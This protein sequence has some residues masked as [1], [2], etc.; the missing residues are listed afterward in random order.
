MSKLL[1]N[2]LVFSHIG[3][4]IYLKNRKDFSCYPKQM[5]DETK[6]VTSSI[7]DNRDRGSV[8]S[9]LSD[10]IKSDAKL[11]FVSAYFTIFA[12]HQLK[13]QLDEVNHLQFLFGEPAF[14][15]SLGGDTNYLRRVFTEY[16]T[17]GENFY[18]DRLYWVF[19][20][21]L[22]NLNEVRE[23]HD[24][25]K[26]K[27]KR[28]DVPYLNGG[29]FEL[30][31]DGFDERGKV[32]LSNERFAEILE[33]FEKYNFTVEESTPYEVQVAID[34]E[35]LGRVFEELVTGRHESG[36]YYTPRQI[37]SFM[38]RESLKYYLA[39][40]DN[41][42]TIAEFVDEGKG[43]NLNN[44]EKILDAI[45]RIRLCDPACGSGAY[46][47]GMMQE[48]LALRQSLFASKHIGDAWILII[49]I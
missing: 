6:F 48:L 19:F 16:E 3:L 10:K 15:K 34:P 49:T 2:S 36:S 44:P 21:G 41:A 45:K 22:S 28:G 11:S 30:E 1:D 23:I 29:L 4:H 20:Y 33:L 26:L 17:H 47:L 40:F 24:D 38:C 13:Q 12:Y 8:G 9:F 5:K 18:A 32:S 46:L 31:K 43:E 27:A 25:E 39:P 37:V 35:I 7:I 42:E 14:I